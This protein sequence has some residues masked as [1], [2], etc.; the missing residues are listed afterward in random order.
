[1]PV[2]TPQNTANASILNIGN[3][4]SLPAGGTPK[5]IPLLVDLTVSQNVLIDLTQQQQG[6]HIGPIQTIYIDNTGNGQAITV[7]PLVSNAAITIPAGDGAIL[8]FFLPGTAPK[9]TVAST[10]G[11]VVPVYV[12]DVPLPACV[13]GASFGGASFQTVN[14]HVSMNVVDTALQALISNIGGAGNALDV[15]VLSSVG[16]GGGGTE[17][18]LILN[19][20]STGAGGNSPAAGAGKKWNVT[21]IDIGVSNDASNGVG[22]TALV[23]VADAGSPFNVWASAEV[24]IPLA[25]VA[26]P[27]P[28]TTKVLS[29][30]NPSGLFTETNA[31][32]AL[33]WGFVGTPL[34]T[35]KFYINMYG[36]AA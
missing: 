5:V 18:V 24:F 36:F 15:N 17:S 11:T 28:G 25:T 34:T 3:G 23:E 33:L 7:N 29:L 21:A 4:L 35:G 16:A 8:P 27:V 2:E 1:M 10:G 13:W 14:G 32:G 12:L 22:Q 26:A 20:Q 19:A 6:G 31:N 9:F 30:S